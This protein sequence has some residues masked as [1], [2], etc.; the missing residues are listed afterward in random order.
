MADRA[1]LTAD[2]SR[3]TGCRL[4]MLA[5]SFANH[6]VHRPGASYVRVEVDE[7]EFACRIFIDREKCRRCLVCVEFCESGA[8]Q[9]KA[10][11]LAASAEGA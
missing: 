5:C 11:P 10:A 9:A 2:A 1:E 3:C 6:R 7:K 4:C 8:L